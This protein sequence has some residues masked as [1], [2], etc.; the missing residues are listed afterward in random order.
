MD[1]LKNRAEPEKQERELLWHNKGCLFGAG[2]SAV[3][4]RTLVL[5][6]TISKRK[7]PPLSGS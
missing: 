4:A 1:G 5:W 3:L 7:T 2:K 6:P